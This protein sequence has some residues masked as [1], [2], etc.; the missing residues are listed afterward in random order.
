MN[1]Q[2]DLMEVPY[3]YPMCLN[4]ECPKAATCLRQQVER[5][6]PE[7][8]KYWT[9]ISPKHLSGLKGACPYYRSNEKVDYAKGFLRCL[10][11]L[12]NRQM[13]NV[14]S[15][16]IS[17]FGQRSYYRI[18]KGERLLSPAEQKVVFNIFKR[19]GVSDLL[20][21]DAYIKGYEW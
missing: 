12:P 3:E 15:H 5:E 9:V 17:K 10:D 8:M 18:R 21:F 19:Y 20:K 13:K 14:I 2:Q 4:R 16:L 6:A 11:E 1:E 7:D